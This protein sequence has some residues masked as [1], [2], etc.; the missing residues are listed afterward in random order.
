MKITTN[1]TISKDEKEIVVSMILKARVVK[2]LSSC[3]G[4]YF[5]SH[6][7]DGVKCSA[8]ERLD[9]NNIIWILKKRCKVMQNNL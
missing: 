6:K 7:C 1:A 8:S 9:K 5:N 3:N 2:N 4:C